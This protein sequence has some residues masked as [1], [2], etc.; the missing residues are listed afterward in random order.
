M[1]L[2]FFV[3]VPVLFA[4]TL[5]SGCKED[6]EMSSQVVVKV[7]D[8]EV[9]INEL[10]EYLK[11]VPFKSKDESKVEEVKQKVLEN[12]VEQKLLLEAAQLA[13]V[14]RSA[15]VISAIEIAK[16]KII[17]DAYLNK[18]LSGSTI[19][20]QKEVQD[21]YNDNEVLFNK[22]K[23]F[24]YDQY[25]IASSPE[26]VDAIVSK[27]KLLDEASELKPFFERLDYKYGQTREYRTTNQL[28]RQ[29][30]KAMSI[31]KEGDIGFFKVLDG[32]V[33]IGL[34]GIES[35]PVTLEQAK[36]AV[37]STLATQKRKDAV[38]MMVKSLKEEAVIEYNPDYSSLVKKDGE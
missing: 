1:N 6:S 33:V 30:V 36:S 16:N 8:K 34:H 28:P 3:L 24:I 25:T 14:H 18:V 11:R 10:N 13:E 35:V 37:S 29:L 26:E 4:L 31:L 9:T 2:K 7:N 5:I 12:L 19:P 17:V 21:F 20:D 38:E 22:R 15:E 32:L 23:R 27:I